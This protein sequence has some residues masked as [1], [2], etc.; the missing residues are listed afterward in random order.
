MEVKSNHLM[1]VKSSNCR[2]F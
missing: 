2:W 1:E